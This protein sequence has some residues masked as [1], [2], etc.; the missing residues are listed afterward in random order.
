M[1]R[2]VRLSGISLNSLGSD[3]LLIPVVTT[4]ESSPAVFAPRMSV[5][6]WSPI[7]TALSDPALRT[8]SINIGG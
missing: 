1:Y 4:T 5:S 3:R 6:S 7:I 8:A 2:G